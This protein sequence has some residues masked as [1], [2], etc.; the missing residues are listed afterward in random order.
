MDTLEVYDG[1]SVAC[2]MYLGRTGN[3]GA[4]TA[5]HLHWGVKRCKA[6]GTSLDKENG[7]YG[8]I[9]FQ[10]EDTYVLDYLGIKEHLT[11]TER[12]RRSV[13]TFNQCIKK[14]L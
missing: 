14:Y 3:T 11:S 4:S 10:Y 1:M 7:Y 5:N 2:G 9:D 6:D 8:G 12:M 13:H